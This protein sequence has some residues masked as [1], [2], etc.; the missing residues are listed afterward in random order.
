MYLNID[1]IL[2][3]LIPF[4]VIFHIYYFRQF[5][6]LLRHELIHQERRNFFQSENSIKVKLKMR[7]LMVEKMVKG[8]IVLNTP[9][10]LVLTNTQYY[11]KSNCRLN[12]VEFKW[13]YWINCS[14]FSHRMHNYRSE[15]R[16]DRP[17]VGLTENSEMF[18]FWKSSC[19]RSPWFKIRDFLPLSHP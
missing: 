12:S 18:F 6:Q 16:V 5:M 14:E 19:Y 4:Q 17:A 8:A 2:I 10:H 15:I 13:I 7:K 3:R 1:S 9:I 11:M